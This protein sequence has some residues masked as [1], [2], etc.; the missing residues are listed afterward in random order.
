MIEILAP[1]YGYKPADIPVIEIGAKAGE[2]LYEELMSQEE[3]N[4]SIE[5]KDM[6]VVTPA[7]KAIYHSISYNYPDTVATKVDN[8]YASAAEK[9][10]SKK[11]LRD[12]LVNNNVLEKVEDSFYRGY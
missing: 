2:K 10:F 11:E 6:F 8:V 3:V 9:A 1:G 5:L 7:F 4:R 12:Y